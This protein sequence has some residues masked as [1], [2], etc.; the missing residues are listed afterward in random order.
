MTKRQKI[1]IGL[2]GLL[3]LPLGFAAWGRIESPQPTS[4]PKLVMP[5]NVTKISE[6]EGFRTTRQYTGILKSPREVRLSFELMGR[7]TKVLVDEG[8]FVSEGALIAKLD[9]RALNA[10][11]QTATANRQRAEAQLEELMA[12]ARSEVRKAAEAE[13][14]AAESDYRNARSNYERRENLLASRSI[15]RE[16][17]EQARYTVQTMKARLDSATQRC[18]ELNNGI[19]PEKISAA[20]AHVSQTEAA[21]QEIRVS[22]ENCEIRA[23]FSG[24]IVRRSVH[25]GS[26]VNPGQ[27]VVDLRQDF[28]L[29]AW[30]GLPVDI[31]N[32]LNP[33]DVVDVSVGE[34][35]F[36]GTIKAKV[37]LLS[38]TTRT[39][40][41]VVQ[42]PN[43]GSN[44]VVAGQVCKLKKEFYEP[45]DGYRV[46][47]TALTKSVRGLWS[48]FVVQDEDGRK[49]ARKADVVVVKS[50]VGFSLV[51]GTLSGQSTIIIDGV[52]RIVSG[53]EVKPNLAVLATKSDN[54]SRYSVQNKLASQAEQR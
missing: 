30:I 8:D 21:I 50:D 45:L 49:V 52:H 13:R 28:E 9:Q 18:N 12:G 40:S 5:V 54:S 42:L 2:G 33:N 36:K 19:R 29:E 11:L 14:K 6:V 31:A 20:K 1:L 24:T 17:L 39:Q 51:Q 22:L 15:S 43:N 35:E 32:E 47:T 46:P 7:V 53:Q 37:R 4:T 38:P 41:V 23:P 34:Q 10:A 25:P 16:E 27:E 26:V 48:L 3:L 44:S